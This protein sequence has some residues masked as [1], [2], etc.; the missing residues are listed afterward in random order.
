VAVNRKGNISGGQD[1]SGWGEAQKKI[2]LSVT[3]R[4]C[5]EGGEVGRRRNTREI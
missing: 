4:R 2:S 5:K 1:L 3:T